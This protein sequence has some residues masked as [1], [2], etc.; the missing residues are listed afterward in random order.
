MST[1]RD[2][3]LRR[4]SKKSNVT[5]TRQSFSINRKSSAKSGLKPDDIIHGES[6][7]NKV[8]QDSHEVVEDIMEIIKDAKEGHYRSSV[9]IQGK[10]EQLMKSKVPAAIIFLL[11]VI[12]V[13]IYA[14][15]L[16]IISM[17]DGGLC[18]GQITPSF[19]LNVMREYGANMKEISFES[20][21]SA[22]VF[23]QE[24]FTWFTTFIESVMGSNI[25]VGIDSLVREYVSDISTEVINTLLG[26]YNYI[27]NIV[28]VP[29]PTYWEQG[30]AGAYWVGD[31]LYSA[32]GGIVY[33]LGTGAEVSSPYVTG[34]ARGV[35]AILSGAGHGTEAVL[36]GTGD[37]LK[38]YGYGLKYVTDGTVNTVA[39]IVLTGTSIV[40]SGARLIGKGVYWYVNRDVPTKLV[41][42]KNV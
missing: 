27:F 35:G 28:E 4:S 18:I 42:H 41:L 7:A 1:L 39:S 5:L 32:G 36:S 29:P 6:L 14:D 9:E 3:T 19:V 26:V 15:A 16:P 22:V 20:I 25:L 12:L 33:A 37:L 23:L 21:G 24:K 11:A 40:G 10:S 17:C 13:S 31:N 8:D 34:A 30:L 2:S 38:G